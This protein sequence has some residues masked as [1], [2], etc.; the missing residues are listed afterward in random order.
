M[1][2]NSRLLNSQSVK[3]ETKKE[4]RMHLETNENEK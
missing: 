4:I 3:E 1:E 2:L